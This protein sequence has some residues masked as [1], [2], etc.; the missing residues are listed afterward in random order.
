MTN[1][2][3][4]A[5]KREIESSREIAKMYDRTGRV[6][7]SIG[8]RDAAYER[9]SLAL[10]ESRKAELLERQLIAAGAAL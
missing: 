7:L 8:N 6:F 3:I 9:R 5:L 4:E 10:H 2:Q 1:R